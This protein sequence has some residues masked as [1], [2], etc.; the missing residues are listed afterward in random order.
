MSIITSQLVTLQIFTGL[1]R[2]GTH[3]TF[4]RYG[5]ILRFE[6]STG[7]NHTYICMYVIIIILC[8][9]V[10][11]QHFQIKNHNNRRLH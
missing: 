9:N 4:Q 3:Q 2:H 11:I 8:I 7:S 5:I 6:K 1:L 10:G